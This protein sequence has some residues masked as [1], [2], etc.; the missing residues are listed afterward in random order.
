M[1]LYGISHFWQIF[2]YNC[3]EFVG[4]E[5]GD[6]GSTQKQRRSSNIFHNYAD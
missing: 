5:F 2:V 3:Q 6:T 4:V 1:Q